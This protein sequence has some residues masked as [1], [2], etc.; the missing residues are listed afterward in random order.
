[1]LTDAHCRNAKP[2]EKLYRLNDQRGLYLEVKPNGVKAWRFR[3]TLDGKPSMFA[4]G[5]YPSLTLSCLIS[6]KSQ[7]CMCRFPTRAT[8]LSRFAALANACGR[9][10]DIAS[11]RIACATSGQPISNPRG[12]PIQ[13]AVG[14]V[15]CPPRPGATM[16]RRN[17]QARRGRFVRSK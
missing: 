15:M 7:S 11:P 10:I 8:L 9:R 16:A 3:F 17:R 2:K 4:L 12:L 1:M 14:S 13:S 6:K 5:E